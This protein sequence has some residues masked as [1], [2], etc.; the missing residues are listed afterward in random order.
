MSIRLFIF[1]LLFFISTS[2]SADYYLVYQHPTTDYINLNFTTKTHKHAHYRH[3]NQHLRRIDSTVLVS[4][5]CEDIRTC[6]CTPGSCYVPKR[7][8]YTGAPTDCV[9]YDAV[10]SGSR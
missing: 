3:I 7:E 1:T 9:T 2:A 6:G 5:E 8:I 4:K 10:L